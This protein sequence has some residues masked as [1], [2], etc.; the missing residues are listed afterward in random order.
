MSSG[1]EPQVPFVSCFL[2]IGVFLE[3]KGNQSGNEIVSSLQSSPF[4]RGGFVKM[5][6]RISEPLETKYPTKGAFCFRSF[7]CREP[8]A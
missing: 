5:E 4:Q 2:P 7:P 8:L 6:T 3:T 1:N